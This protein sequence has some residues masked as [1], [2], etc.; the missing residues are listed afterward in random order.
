MAVLY[1]LSRYINISECASS[2][3]LRVADSVKILT[4][5]SM[6]KFEDFRR[7]REKMD[8]STR[9][10]SEHQWGQAY[11][12]YCS[13]RENPR[14]GRSSTAKDGSQRRRNSSSAAGM[15]GPSTLSASG[16]LKAHIRAESAYADL[17]LIVNLLSWVIL[18]TILIITILQG[19]L[20]PLP[21]ATSIAL[22]SGAIKAL[23]VVV[24][25]LV[26]HVI[27][28]IPDVALYR[29]S[30]AQRTASVAAKD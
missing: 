26:V 28:D 21:G 16:A 5:P 20:F 17:R 1:I 22:L 4:N 18:A 14:G 19:M 29:A 27:I 3:R 10:L 7:S 12:A 11:A 8:P 6:K 15:H 13:A 24:L 23:G 9:K 2:L 25:R 30:A